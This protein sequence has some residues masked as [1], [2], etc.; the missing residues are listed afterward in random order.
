MKHDIEML[1]LKLSDGS[2]VLRLCEQQSGL[3]LE[4]RLES[5]E[6]I[7]RQKQRWMGVFIAMLEREL[8]TAN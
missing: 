5:A 8:G 7:A 2:R 4:K 1:L 6:S 3:C